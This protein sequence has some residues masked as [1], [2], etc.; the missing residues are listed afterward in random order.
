M[1]SICL[2][3]EMLSAIVDKFKKYAII[4]LL[5]NE[6]K[7]SSMPRSIF[8]FESEDRV[9]SPERLNEYIRVANSGIWAVV[10]ALILVLVVLLI[11]GFTGRIP[12][13]S[14]FKG[15]VDGTLDYNIDV[16]VDAFEFAGNNLVGKEA[17]FTLPDGK[18][19]KGVVVASTDVP[20]SKEEMKDILESD[21]L[22][23]SLVS[24]DY[25][26]ILQLKPEEDLSQYDLQLAEI[27]IITDELKP[28]Y[29]L[30]N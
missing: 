24:Y 2:A 22:S 11:W 27:T 16:V 25:S 10:C 14:E 6:R 29:F 18:K 30:M 21:F 19:G 3:S 28:I 17:I 26:Y 20:F 5:P 15:V 13:S 8:D 9:E 12:K 7:D 23:A 1:F 4:Y